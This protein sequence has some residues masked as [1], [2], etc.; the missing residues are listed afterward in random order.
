MPTRDGSGPDHEELLLLWVARRAGVLDALTTD[1]GTADGVADATALDHDT[2]SRI[3]RLLDE[4]GYLH[5][6]G[7]EYEV[8]NRALGFLATRDVRSIGVTPH[9]LDRLD[10]L[11]ELGGDRESGSDTERDDTDGDEDEDGGRTLRHRLG[12]H[13]ATATA[14]VRAS[15]T[16]AVHT[17][18]DAERV[19]DVRGAS[20]VYA[21]EFARRGCDVTLV[22]TGAVLDI[23]GP[24]LT[25][26]GVQT[27]ESD[28]RTELPVEGADLA[29]LGGVLQRHAPETNRELLGAVHDALAPGGVIVV[30]EPLRGASGAAQRVAVDRLAAGSGDAYTGEAVTTWLTTAGFVGPETRAIP[31]TEYQTVVSRRERG[32]D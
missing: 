8:T 25:G 17:A 23:V 9:A 5:P 28:S 31:G 15:V 2:A 1:A 10:V 14:V 21:T 3:V 13:A 12:A 4:Y 20:G 19:L 7:D 30:V 27:V 22:D 16:A 26:Q 11:A 24:M 6:V 32:V 29:F 18:P